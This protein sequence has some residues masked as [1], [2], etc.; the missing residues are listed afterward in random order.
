MSTKKYKQHR[1]R[2]DGDQTQLPFLLARTPLF[3]AADPTKLRRIKDLKERFKKSQAKGKLNEEMDFIFSK[4]ITN[5]FREKSTIYFNDMI[6]AHP[7]MSV[8]MAIVAAFQKYISRVDNVKF[9][10]KKNRKYV[11][12]KIPISELYQLTGFT[13]AHKIRLINSLDRLSCFKIKLDQKRSSSANRGETYH[14]FTLPLLYD[15]EK[16]HAGEKCD[17]VRFLI[18]NAFLPSEKNLFRSAKQCAALKSDTAR[19]LF[20]AMASRSHLRASTQ[21]LHSIVYPDAKN[22][23]PKTICDWEKKRL[24]KA[25]IELQEKCGWSILE[26]KSTG[27]WLIKLPSRNAPTTSEDENDSR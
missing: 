13:A 10:K 17:Q 4:T 23:A 2:P 9:V 11:E 27:K 6:R 16:R 12:Y 15:I 3:Q 14:S 25:V 1:L 21:E 8:L 5:S 22:V 24:K 19:L 18:H 26:E 7:D 20:W